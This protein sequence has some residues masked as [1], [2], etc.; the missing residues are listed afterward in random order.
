MPHNL[1][2]RA[3]AGEWS[4][5]L[6]RVTRSM[7]NNPVTQ[8]IGDAAMRSLGDILSGRRNPPRY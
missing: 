7:N 2:I 4:D 8:Q 5:V 3:M 6:D 1:V